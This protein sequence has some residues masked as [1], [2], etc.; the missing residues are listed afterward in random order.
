M[1]IPSFCLYLTKI[2]FLKICFV[3]LVLHS[4]KFNFMLYV[5]I[6]VK[7]KYFPLQIPSVVHVYSRWYFGVNFG[8]IHY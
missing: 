8:W 6:S 7:M 2:F 3:Y 1:N 5:R 4:G